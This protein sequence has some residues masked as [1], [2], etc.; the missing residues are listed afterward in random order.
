MVCY[1]CD[2]DKYGIILPEQLITNA[3]T[4]RLM[5]LPLVTRIEHEYSS[6]LQTRLNCRRQ[7]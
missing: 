3:N 2:K 1:V 6:T 4:H 5:A 7:L